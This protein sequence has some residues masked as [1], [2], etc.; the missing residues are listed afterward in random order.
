MKPCR[1]CGKQPRIN[2]K[3]ALYCK[4]CL[5]IGRGR[6]AT[7]VLI[8]VNRRKYYDKELT[9]KGWRGCLGQHTHKKL[10]YIA[11]LDCGIGYYG[12]EY[13]FKKALATLKNDGFK[14]TT[15]SK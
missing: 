14:F 9:N 5:Q 13:S 4:D 3:H 1:S 11:P 6:K 12:Y 2:E 10:Y 8:R 7:I 15:F